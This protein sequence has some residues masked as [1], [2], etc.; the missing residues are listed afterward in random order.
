[1]LLFPRDM[2]LVLKKLIKS[3]AILDHKKS[4][5]FTVNAIANK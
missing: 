3:I 1:M 5:I 2:R 4:Y